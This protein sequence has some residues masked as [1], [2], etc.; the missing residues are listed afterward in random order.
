MCFLGFICHYCYFNGDVIKIFV[1]IVQYLT[2]IFWVKFPH[3][4][5]SSRILAL[6][7]KGISLSTLNLLLLVL[8]LILCL[9]LRVL[10]FVSWDPHLLEN[11]YKLRPVNITWAKFIII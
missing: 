7:L 2:E 1:Y 9:A 5:I 11:D 8:C 6:P 10:L 3:E 4:K